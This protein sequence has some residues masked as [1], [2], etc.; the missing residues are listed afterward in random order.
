MQFLKESRQDELN[1]TITALVPEDGKVIEAYTDVNYILYMQNGQEYIIIMIPGHT[2][3]IHSSTATFKSSAIVNNNSDFQYS[4]SNIITKPDGKAA[5]RTRV[6]GIHK[7]L[8][9]LSNLRKF[10]IA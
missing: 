6:K 9:D 8:G 3:E 10:T 1:S 7:D 4:G 5:I 2:P